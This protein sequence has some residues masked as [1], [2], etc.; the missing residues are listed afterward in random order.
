M[1][2]HNHHLFNTILSLDDEQVVNG[3]L[4]VLHIGMQIKNKGRIQIN[5]S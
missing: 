2:G 1:A 3:G 5:T 4:P